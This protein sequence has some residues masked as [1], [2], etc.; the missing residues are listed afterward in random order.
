MKGRTAVQQSAADEAGP[1]RQPS[2]LPRRPELALFT[3]AFGVYAYFFQ[4]GGWN[5]NSRFDL[6]RAIVEQHTLTIDD[7]AD[8]TGDLAYFGGH[9]YSEK[10][11]GL[12]MAAVPVYAA[13]HPFAHGQR[14][15]GRLI[16]LAAYLSTLVAVSL[17]SALTV[18]TLFRIS[19]WLGAPAAA[20][21]AV[22]VAYAFGTL[23]LPYATL[24]YAHQLVAALLFGSFA[25]LAVGRRR[26][27]GLGRG[28]LFVVGLLL[29]SA[30]AS[31]YPAALIAGVILLYAAAVTRPWP[32]L[33]W[34]AAGAAAPLL[35]L[36]AYHTAAFGGPLTV[37]YVGSVD[38][39]RQGGLWLGITL[40]DLTVLGKVL[41]ST[42]RGLL[43]H[44][45]WLALAAPGVIR[46]VRSR[47]ACVEGLFCLAVLLV[48]L[49][50]NSSLTRTPDDWRGGA[51]V[52]TRVLVPWL[53]FFALGVAGLVSPPP[54]AWAQSTIVRAVVGFTFAALVAV[55]AGRMFL[56]TAIR[57][58]VNHVHDP[59]ADYYLP[60][61]HQDKVAVNAVPFHNGNAKPKEAWN[62]G[63]RMGLSGRISLLPLAAFVIATGF[64]LAAT[65]RGRPGEC[66]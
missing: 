4:A 41:F 63:E 2:N 23:A 39:N 16:H 50:F 6:T 7:Y 44:A 38:P 1:P 34:L 8:N 43:H 20:G 52:G 28:R 35:G 51:G 21:A 18:A 49:L 15:R 17:P 10:A 13:L 5:Q 65:V 27:E 54:K 33:A 3:L 29:G 26:P 42:E 62:L 19:R 45:P 30:I 47:T 56:A 24:F 46:M 32:R 58:E 57:P 22:A 64:W 36:A 59:F 40:P 12:S 55:S 53:P 37:A 31:E 25:L 60:L 11:P 48:G 14:P 61:W 9:T 66:A